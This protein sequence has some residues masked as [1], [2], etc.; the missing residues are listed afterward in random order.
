LE[1]RLE[2]AGKHP[3]PL[4]VFVILDGK[5]EFLDKHLRILAEKESLKRVCLGI[6][7]P[8][9]DYEVSGEADV[10]VVIY[11]PE[12]R[13]RQ[14]VRANFAFRKGE[15][16]EEKADAVAKALADVLPK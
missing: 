8:P 15:L 2:D 12:R 4:G 6:A 9:R 7:A 11:N 10:T 14:S 5:P 13:F 1:T 16:T 3:R